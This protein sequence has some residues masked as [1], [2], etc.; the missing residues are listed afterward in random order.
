MPKKKLLVG[1]LI[2][3]SWCLT[4]SLSYAT[5]DGIGQTIQIITRFNGWV[6]KPSWLL[7]IR[8]LDHNQNVPY[9]FDINKGEN[10]WVALT[11]GRNY[12]ISASNLQ[13]ET[14]YPRKNIFKN[15]RIH[16]FCHLESNGRIIHG[17]SMYITISGELTPNSDTYSCNIIQFPEEKFTVVPSDP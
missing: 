16:N 5:D 14:Y 6:G 2:L 11:Y 3:S 9:L 15:Y 7:V 1:F 12:L 10:Y 13:I 17:E 8:D 4:A